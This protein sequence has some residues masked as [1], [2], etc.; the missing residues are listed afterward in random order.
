[1][2]HYA[3]NH[4]LASPDGVALTFTRRSGAT[5]LFLLALLSSLLLLGAGARKAAGAQAALN[6]SVYLPLVVNGNPSGEMPAGAGALIFGE[7]SFRSAAMAVDGQGRMHVAFSRVAPFLP[8]K[9]HTV[10]YGT[11]QPAQV[12]CGQAANWQLAQVDNLEAGWPWVQLRLTPDGRPRLMLMRPVMRDSFPL[13]GLSYRYLECNTHCTTAQAWWALDITDQGT[14]GGMFNTDYSYRTFAL[15]H[16]GRPRFIYEDRA[17]SAGAHAGAY[18]VSCDGNCTQPGNWFETRI[19]ASGDNVYVD[20]NAVLVFS[21]DGRPRIFARDGGS[22]T[23]PSSKLVYVECNG[24]CDNH[25][26]WSAPLRLRSINSG[27]SVHTWSPA[28]TASGGVRLSFYPRGGPFFYLW[29]DGDCSQIDHWG[30]YSLDLGSGTGDYS[31]LTLDSQGRP[32]I[33]LRDG[34][35]FGLSYLWCEGACETAAAQWK[36]GLVEPIGQLG[37]EHPIRPLPTCIRGGWF[38]GL[39]PVMVLDAHDNARFAYDAEYKMECLKNP[40]NPNDPS[41]YVE[42]KWWTSRFI[43]L[44]RPQAQAAGM[45]AE[46]VPVRF[47]EAQID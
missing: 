15:D 35:E 9:Q 29:C 42:T 1:V 18:Y 27:S 25:A 8:G 21:P 17:N 12:D 38:G 11:C 31:A 37:E 4:H 40:G 14:G 7:D 43:Y 41:T 3:I 5:W 10:F 47:F 33:A 13:G 19:D 22:W 45:M 32:H 24:S 39:R 34:D 26:H 23:D 16:L 28:I 2:R 6:S 44:P 30:E 46:L 36:M 20:E